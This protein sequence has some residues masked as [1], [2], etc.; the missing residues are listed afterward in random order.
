MGLDNG[1]IVKRTEYTET[2]PE[3]RQFD[4]DYNTWQKY[5]FEVCYWRKCYNIRSMIFDKICGK[6]FNNVIS[7]QLN[8]EDIDNIIVGLQS[9]NSENW[10]EDGGSIWDWDDPDYPYSEKVQRDIENLKMLRPL[11]DKYDLEVYFYDSY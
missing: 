7:D 10:H 3:L 4:E 1:I 2:I 9:F 5:P 6:C 11:M 8:K